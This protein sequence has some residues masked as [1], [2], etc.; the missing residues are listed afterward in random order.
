VS[1]SPRV[2]QFVLVD[3]LAVMTVAMR[4]DSGRSDDDAPQ[5]EEFD[6]GDEYYELMDT[7]IDKFDTPELS[8]SSPVNAIEAASNEQFG[9]APSPPA[10]RLVL[11]KDDR[12]AIRIARK[13]RARLQRYRQSQAELMELRLQ[14]VQLQ[15]RIAQLKKRKTQCEQDCKLSDLLGSAPSPFGFNDDDEIDPREEALPKAHWSIASVTN[16][17]SMEDTARIEWRQ[18]R[19]AEAVQLKLMRVSVEYAHR[20][21]QFRSACARLQVSSDLSVVHA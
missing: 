12:R 11:S 21:E 19:R 6:L 8:G 10:A 20:C 2:F 7:L 18:R 13:N 9:S 3:S 4:C 1:S 5:T 16:V 14:V 15:G 17:M